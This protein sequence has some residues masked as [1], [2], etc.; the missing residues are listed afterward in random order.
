MSR[1]D[2]LTGLIT[3]VLIAGFIVC[4]VLCIRIGKQVGNQRTVSE[5]H[6]SSAAQVQVA[7]READKEIRE[8]EQM[9][10]V[11]E[12]SILSN[13]EIA[14]KVEALEELIR[15]NY[16][17]DV[18]EEA[19]ANGLYS[20][21][22]ES[23]N[24]P[25]AAYYTPEEWI[26]MQQETQGIYYGIGAYLQK[27]A[28]TLYPR[29]T[30][31]IK[32]TPAEETG[33]LEDD[34]IIEVGGEDVYDMELTDVVARIKGEEGTKVHLVVVRGYLTSKQEELEFDV[35]RR[36]VE[37]PTVEYEMMDGDIAYI[38]I[39]EFDS[40]TVEQF[41]EALTSAKAA[42]AKGLVL[43]LRSNPGGSVGA[44]VRIARM[45]L[46]AGRI[47]YTVDKYGHEESYDC[48]GS[49]EIDIPMV[50]LINGNSASAAEILAGAIKDY[51]VGTLLGTQTFGKGIVQQI[52]TLSDGS[53]MKLTVSHY[54][55]PLG[56]DIHK[57]GIEPDQIVEFDRDAYLE[58]RTDNQLDAALEL[59]R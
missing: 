57:V 30:G 14:G 6:G 45:L 21:L 2:F 1:K 52:F 41:E 22:M 43:D 25:Y 59:L 15:E 9:P 55:T 56:N 31:I 39:A 50:V 38:Q 40:V 12:E 13:P 53:A 51:G 11:S 58:D 8:P 29:I 4:V 7:P 17:D 23:L 20:G 35:E 27:D 3:G 24:D 5:Q 26:S 37:T 46:P 42:N 19:L 28:D 36:R 18:D 54:Y 32:N 44:V 47:V 48:D 10:D 16:I 34:I 49:N 33:L